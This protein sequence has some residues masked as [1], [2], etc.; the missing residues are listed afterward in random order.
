MSKHSSVGN[1]RKDWAETQPQWGSPGRQWVRAGHI[2][3]N[4]V[5][6][7]EWC[8]PWGAWLIILRLGSRDHT[9]Q[10][11]VDCCFFVCL[12][13]REKEWGVGRAQRERHTESEAESRLWAVSTELDAGFKFTNWTQQPW[14]RGLS[15]SRKL[16]RLSPPEALKLLTLMYLPAC[17]CANSLAQRSGFLKQYVFFG[18]QHCWFCINSS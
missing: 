2:N 7:L 15:G 6:I 8:N 16:N 1:R 18:N 5:R 14:D 13:L 17:K 12:F 9:M 3:Y 4:K 11:P 10:K